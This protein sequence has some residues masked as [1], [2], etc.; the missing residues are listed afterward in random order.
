MGCVKEG[1]SFFFASS[2]CRSQPAQANPLLQ[3]VSEAG[4]QRF[5]SRFYSA[6]H[7]K[8]SQPQLAFNPRVAKLYDPPA[9]PI[10]LLRFLA[11]HLLSEGLHHHAFFQTHDRTSA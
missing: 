1:S 5:G 6:A 4:P 9:T 11:S 8:L 3:V 2:S 10:L 7:V